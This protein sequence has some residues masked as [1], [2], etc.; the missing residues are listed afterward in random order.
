MIISIDID[1]VLVDRE[2]YQIEKAIEYA[3][4]N[5]LNYKVLNQYA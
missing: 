3:K 4:N 5:N 2:N 1:G